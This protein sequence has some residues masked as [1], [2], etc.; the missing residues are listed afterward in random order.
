MGINGKS[1][2]YFVN[3]RTSSIFDDLFDDDLLLRNVCDIATH[4]VCA[5]VW[6]LREIGVM[7]LRPWLTLVTLIA[8]VDRINRLFQQII[9][10]T[11][12]SRKGDDS[13][14]D[15]SSLFCECDLSV[16]AVC[17]NMYLFS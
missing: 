8:I 15:C 3:R 12:G 4:Y 6:V 1:L 13:L 11:E 10:E 16:F 7:P 2:N 9:I 5:C 17:I 14:P